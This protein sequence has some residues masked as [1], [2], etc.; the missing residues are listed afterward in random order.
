[1]A[2]KMPI[3]MELK[4]NFAIGGWTDLAHRG[5]L[6]ELREKYGAAAALEIFERVCKEGDRVKR[7]IYTILTIFN[8][9][10]N[11]A[12]TIGDV[13]DIWDEIYGYESSILERSPIINRRKVIKCPFKTEHKDISEWNLSFTKII[14]QTINPKL[15][16]ERSKAMCEGDPSCEYVWKL[17]E[18]IQLKGDEE[19]I[20]KTL[21]TPC[22]APKRGLPWELKYN[23]AM[24]GFSD[25][26]RGFMYAIREK[27]GAEAVLELYERVSKMGDRAKNLT[28]TLLKIFNIEGNDAETIG[29]WWDI[30]GE[31]LGYESVIVERSPTINRR[32][33]IKCPLKMEYKDIAEWALP[34]HRIITKTINPKLTVERPKAMCEGD[35]YCE[36]VWKLE[37]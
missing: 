37:E 22:V 25:F 7:L 29:E 2:K 21:E 16:F 5:P 6:Y 17:E 9:M 32:K 4:W 18:N 24:K 33:V 14:T 31:I 20:A 13:L 27:Y 23:F 8:L 19:P 36:Y 10:D 34:F 3:P 35:P 12:E 11:D 28:N 26:N 30:W 1:M 15:T